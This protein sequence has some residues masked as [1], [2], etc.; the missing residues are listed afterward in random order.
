M[1]ECGRCPIESGRI[2][3][4]RPPHLG[5]GEAGGLGLDA[6]QLVPLVLGDVLGHQGVAGLD[7][8]EGG[9]SLKR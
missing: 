7:G 1:W 4:Q 5:E 3:K 2:P 9:R 6:G 8:R